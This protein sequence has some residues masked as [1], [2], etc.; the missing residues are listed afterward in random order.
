MK[1]LLEDRKSS[2]LQRGEENLLE[3]IIRH[4]DDEETQI[5]DIMHF[6]MG[7]QFTTGYCKRKS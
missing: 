7:G 6:S 5:A 4:T 1:Q 2:S 3:L